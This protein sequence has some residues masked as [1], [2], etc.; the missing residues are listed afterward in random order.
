MIRRFPIDVY[1]RQ[2][3]DDSGNGRLYRLPRFNHLDP[4]IVI[5]QPSLIENLWVLN[6]KV[7]GGFD[8]L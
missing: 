1:K 8:N 3:E 7:D 4:I 6:Q 2:I 5:S